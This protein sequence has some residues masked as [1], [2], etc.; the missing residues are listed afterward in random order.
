[1]DRKIEKK[2]FLIP[3]KYWPWAVGGTV[4]L[5]LLAWLAAGSYT[6][7]LK[8][9]RES[10]IISPV[11][12]GEFNDYIALHGHVAP[13]QVVQVSPEEGGI[14][15]ERVV[16]EGARVRKGDVLIRLSNA[17]L[18]LQILNA[19]SE[20]AE[21]Q[22]MLRNTQITMEQDRLNNSYEE[23]QLSQDVVAKRRH[24]KRQEK[25]HAERLIPQEDWLRAKED[26]ELAH[27]KHQLVKERL[28]KDSLLRQSQMEQMADNLAAMQRNVE[29]V[30]QRKERLEV[31]AQID[32]EVGLLDVELGQSV[33]AGG[34][35]GVVNDLS[36]FKVSA[37]VDEH[38]IDRV[39]GGLT[40]TFEQGGKRYSMR[41]RKVFPEVRERRFRTEFVFSGERPDNLR[42]GQSFYMD[43]QLGESKQA[44][45]IPKGTFYSVTGGSWIFVL[46][47]EGK[48]AY[49]RQIR[50]GRQNPEHYEVMKGLEPGEQVI[51]NGYE[52]FKDMETIVIKD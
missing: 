39:T 22:N 36:D 33:A 44:I 19:E 20:L 2:K 50:I 14:V 13:I 3:T 16:E 29:L 40:A 37:M 31:R 1:M 23:L 46:D 15:Q 12:K 49:R 47:K 52:S 28:H 51:V 4:I 48:K 45:I 21:K 35:I 10:L 18:N 38:Y 32:G 9:E 42:T 8:V 27:K 34:K 7:V 24:W 26:Y 25:L 30:R 43:L 11:I 6:S 41:L 17:N 5:A